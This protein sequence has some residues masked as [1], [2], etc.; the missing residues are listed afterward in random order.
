MKALVAISLV[1]ALGDYSLAQAQTPPVAN[2]NA[3]ENSAI[4]DPHA[5]KPGAP[6]AGHNSFTMEQAR[7]HIEKAG[8]IKVIGLMKDKNGLWQGRA[9]KNGQQVAVSMDYQG[10]VASN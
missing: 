3:P 1:V 6:A 10:N 4:K 7:K 2:P 8:Y 5:S 9:E